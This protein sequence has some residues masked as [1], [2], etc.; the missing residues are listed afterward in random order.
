MWLLR[1]SVY[2]PGTA[3]IEEAAISLA[4][5]HS[6]YRIVGKLNNPTTI[7]KWLSGSYF[8]W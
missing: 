7:Q 2:P 4:L 3:A 8:T 1:S 6:D 5:I